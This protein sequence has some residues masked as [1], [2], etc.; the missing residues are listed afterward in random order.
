LRKDEARICISSLK[1]GLKVNIDSYDESGIFLSKLNGITD[2]EKKRKII[3]NQFIYSFEKIAKKFGNI[4][5]L[6]QGTLY[7]DVI[8]SG[9]S[10]GNTSKLIKS[11]HNVG[12]LPKNMKFK[13]IEPIRELFKDEVRKVGIQLGIPP[14]L[15]QRH[16]FPGPGL[17]VRI[18]GEI[19]KER[20]KILQEA[21]KIYID[22]LQKNKLYD[23][24]W[25]AF[26]VL[27]PVKT[28][29][30]MGDKRTYENLIGLRA[31]TSV[32][33][34]TADWFDMPHDILNKISTQIINSVSGVNRVVYDIT[35]KPPG[36]IEWE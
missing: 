34:M 1:E 17:A 35:S 33:G 10:L 13:L 19:T 27:I 12:G 20:I 16:P 26:A 5:Y 25:Q 31:V 3:G 22:I 29:G 15:I 18:I 2:P 28:V 30:V 21:D 4:E 36:T 32:D 6:A 24:I 7:P 14:S 23:Q 9:I 11:H 8:E